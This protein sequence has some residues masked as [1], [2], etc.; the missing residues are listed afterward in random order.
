MKFGKNIT[1]LLLA[2]ILLAGCGA[3]PSDTETAAPAAGETENTNTPGTEDAGTDDETGPET[4]PETETETEQETE[5]ETEPPVVYPVPPEDFGGYAFRIFDASASS[6]AYYPMY[7]A[8]S[9]GEALSAAV[10]NRNRKIEELYNCTIEEASA[11]EYDSI[12]TSIIVGEDVLDMALIPDIMIMKDLSQMFIAPWQEARSMDLSAEWWDKAANERYNLNDVQIA[13]SGAFNLNNYAGRLCYVYNRTLLESRTFSS[14]MTEYNYADH[15]FSNAISG[16]WAGDGDFTIYGDKYSRY[17]H[18][19][20]INGSTYDYYRTMLAGSGVDFYNLTPENELELSFGTGEGSFIG[21]M[22]GMT[23]D[24]DLVKF[25]DGM[26]SSLPAVRDLAFTS[27]EMQML[28]DCMNTS[29]LEAFTSCDDSLFLNGESTFKIVRLDEIPALRETGMDLGI[30]TLPGK[31]NVSLV[32]R[33]TYAVQYVCSPEEHKTLVLM[34][35]LACYSMDEVLPAFAET[36]VGPFDPEDKSSTA[37]RNARMVTE[38]I[39]KNPY[40]E[41]S[42]GSGDR[43]LKYLYYKYMLRYDVSDLW[44]SGRFTEEQFRSKAGLWIKNMQKLNLTLSDFLEAYYVP[45]PFALTETISA[46]VNKG[47]LTLSGTGEIPAIYWIDDI[48]ELLDIGNIASVVIE[49]GITSVGNSAFKKFD[50]LKEITLPSSVTVI[51]EDAFYD[52]PLEKVVLAEGLTEIKSSAFSSC[53]KLESITLPSTLK[54]MGG[55]VFGY[56]T[57]LKSVTIPAGVSEMGEYMFSGCEA[58]ETAVIEAH[59]DTL[60]ACTFESCASL[61]SVTLSDTLRT[62]D[63]W[64]F[65][66]CGLRTLTLPSGLEVIGNSVFMGSEDLETVEIPES[67]HTI[68]FSAF[69]ECYSLK[70]VQLP[71][72]LTTL[73]SQ[74]FEYCYSLEE[75]VIPDGISMIDGSTFDGCKSLKTVTIP[76]SVTLIDDYAFASCKISDVYYGGTQADWDAIEIKYKNDSIKEAVIH[77]AG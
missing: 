69:E 32:D 34:E 24:E 58:L 14:G 46:T 51:G 27:M 44:H 5:P 7:P 35:A 41:A 45:V 36:V 23:P 1:A 62:L 73:G 64:A 17:T 47:V 53:D 67:V 20:G 15:L 13:L 28:S 57:A 65:R 29:G 39:F 75:I 72:G 49:E 61:Q 42:I 31:A 60:P 12:Y 48:K 74:V 63:T 37:A 19:G 21:L 4:E 8:E 16:S 40:Y 66:K 77:F 18:S 33:P 25:R 52:L 76:K 2:A 70:N 26:D 54:T 68:D 10:Y 3:T 9:E 22:D 71:A 6:D 30:V 11:A 43:E 38:Q 55:R 59:I 56:C 50:K